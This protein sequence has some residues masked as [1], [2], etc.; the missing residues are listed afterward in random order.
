MPLQP[1]SRIVAAAPAPTRLGCEQILRKL[2]ISRIV[3]TARPGSPG[4]KFKRVGPKKCGLI[5]GQLMAS[6]QLSRCYP[7]STMTAQTNPP[8]VPATP[9]VP[10]VPAVPF[11]LDA[12]ALARLRDLDPDGRHGVVTRVLTAFEASLS[13]MLAQLQGERG[14]HHPTAVAGVAHMLKSSS[15]SVGALS[16]AK[17]CADVELKLR[18]GDTSALQADITQLISEGESALQAVTAILRA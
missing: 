13:R 18:Q 15:A 9:A 12:A 17:A 11:S 1:A 8:A 2:G 6:F 4:L 16:L 7:L 3:R 10:A 5:A 14:A